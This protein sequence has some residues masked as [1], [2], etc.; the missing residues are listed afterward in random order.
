LRRPGDSQD[1]LFVSFVSTVL[2][3][4]SD[5][6]DERKGVLSWLLDK[7][8]QAFGSST[9]NGCLGIELLAPDGL[10]SDNDRPKWLRRRRVRRDSCVLNID[11]CTV[12]RLWEVTNGS[13]PEFLARFFK[14]PA[15]GASA[16]A[17]SRAV[18]ARR[19]GLALTGGGASSYRMVPFIEGLE[20]DGRVPI[21]L[22]SGVSGGALLGSYYCAKGLR[23]LDLAV[24]QG[25]SFEFSTVCSI[26][27]SAAI[28]ERVDTDLGGIRVESLERRFVPVTMSLP[29]QL[30]ARRPGRSRRP[31]ACT[32]VQGTVGQAVRASGS[33]PFV[34]SP[35]WICNHHFVDGGIGMQLPARALWDA[36]ADM[37]IAC[38]SVPGPAVANPFSSVPLTDWVYRS[39]ILGRVSDAV[40]SLALYVQRASQELANDADVYVEV[41]DQTFPLAEMF[42]FSRG[43]EICDES[44]RDPKVDDGIA[45]STKRWR[46]FV[47]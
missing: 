43:R 11:A 45:A 20:S 39:T 23:G 31:E 40:V 34:V 37:V 26:F 42:F 29:D 1:F 19:V 28:E 36:G 35:T 47:S 4:S 38:N 7:A 46:E 10:P 8:G 16:A 33:L 22:V 2:L 12:R 21:D 41:S 17:W 6:D 18:T 5:G 14:T 9:E 25:W 32:I 27:N 13:L 24:A 44:S 3:A 15:H 30:P